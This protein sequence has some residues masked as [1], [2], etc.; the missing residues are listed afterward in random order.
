MPP[1]NPE[2]RL[3]SQ[4][5][6]TFGL[7]ARKRFLKEYHPNIISYRSFAFIV[8]SYILHPKIPEIDTHAPIFIISFIV[9]YKH[10]P[11]IIRLLKREEGKVV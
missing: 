9:F 8:S 1:P 2:G 6:L 11:N 4:V 7:I 3:I 10:I 5:S